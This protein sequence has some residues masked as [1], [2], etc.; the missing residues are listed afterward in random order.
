MQRL[1]TIGAN[2]GLMLLGCVVAGTVLHLWRPNYAGALTWAVGAGLL[3]GV[4]EVQIIRKYSKDDSE[5]FRLDGMIF[6]FFAVGV[7][8]AVILFQ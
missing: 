2:L 4:V 8:A 5:F 7:S 3:I 6:P 1:L